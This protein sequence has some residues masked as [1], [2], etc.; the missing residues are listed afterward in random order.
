MREPLR[1][2]ER[3]RHI[4][5]AINTIQHQ[6]IEEWENQIFTNPIAFYGLTKLVEII[7][8]AAWK[9]TKEFRAQHSEVEWEDI[10]GMRHILVH[11]YY[12]ISPKILLEVVK[13]DIPHLKKQIELLLGI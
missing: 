5:E 7:G 12:T 8:E 1:D 6:S 4:L 13:Q 11:D 2:P 3:L 9:L 10:M